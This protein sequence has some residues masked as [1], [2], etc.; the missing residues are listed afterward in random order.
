MRSL[1]ALS[2]YLMSSTFLNL[3]ECCYNNIIKV[4]AVGLVPAGF[5]GMR[6]FLPEIGTVFPD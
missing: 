1:T 4:I 3:A 5:M 6:L 2:C